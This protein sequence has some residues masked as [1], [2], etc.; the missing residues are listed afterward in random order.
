MSSQSTPRTWGRSP[1]SRLKALALN[2][3]FSIAARLYA[4]VKEKRRMAEEAV[5]AGKARLDGS[6]PI[7][8]QGDLSLYSDAA[9]MARLNLQRNPVL[10]QLIQKVGSARMR[11]VCVRGGACCW[12][13]VGD[14][15]LPCALGLAVVVALF[16]S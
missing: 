9:L 16:D 4:E 11:S 10:V 2:G 15:D 7:A 14:W 12:G 3:A 6:A 8:Q 1:W 5:A 13:A